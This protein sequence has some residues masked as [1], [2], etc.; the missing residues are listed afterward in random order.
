MTSSWLLF[1][2]DGS[3]SNETRA[4]ATRSLNSSIPLVANTTVGSNVSMTALAQEVAKYTSPAE[5]YW[6]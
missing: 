2:P 1:Y 3:S 5:E 4:N 6:Q